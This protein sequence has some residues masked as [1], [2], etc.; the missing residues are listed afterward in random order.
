MNVKTTNSW[1]FKINNN[2]WDGLIGK[3]VSGEADL[4]ITLNAFRSERYEAVDYSA[5]SNWRH[6]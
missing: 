1:G 3:L 5:V 4:S 2:T 6:Q